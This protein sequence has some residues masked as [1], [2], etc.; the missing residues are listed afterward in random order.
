[1]MNRVYIKLDCGR[2]IKLKT[3]K[4]AVSGD[5]TVGQL[6]FKIR[7]VVRLEASE[8]IYLFWDGKALYPSHAI[9]KDIV[10]ELCDE[11][12]KQEL[13]LLVCKESTFG[14]LDKRF[15]RAIIKKIGQAFELRITYSYY[16]MYEYDVVFV[17]QSLQE[18]KDRLLTERCAGCLTIDVEG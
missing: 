17:C 15:I 6:L 7:Q 5:M 9:I 4:V 16:G 8:A 2:G 14:G 3:R 12:G 11:D 13:R 10:R 18:A 1:M